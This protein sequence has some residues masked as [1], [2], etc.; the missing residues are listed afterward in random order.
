MRDWGN[1]THGCKDQSVGLVITEKT[2]SYLPEPGRLGLLRLKTVIFRHGFI[3]DKQTRGS[4]VPRD[5]VTKMPKSKPLGAQA[6]FDYQTKEYE[7][8]IFGRIGSRKM[9]HET[10]SK[11]LGK[12]RSATSYS[13]KDINKMRFGEIRKLCDLLGIEVILKKKE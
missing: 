8:L 13:L 10:I 1:L 5:E 12:T 7:D 2:A 4:G 3:L 9:T 6:R 11:S